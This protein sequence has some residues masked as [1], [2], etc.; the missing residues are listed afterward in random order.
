MTEK[1]IMISGD[2]NDDDLSMLQYVLSHVRGSS[3]VSMYNQADF[4]YDEAL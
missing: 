4:D 3:P 1:T 2:M